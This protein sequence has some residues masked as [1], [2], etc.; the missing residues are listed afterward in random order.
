MSNNRNQLVKCQNQYHGGRESPKPSEMVTERN[1][2]IQRA[3]VPPSIKK[4]ECAH[5]CISVW[6][7][8]KRLTGV[9]RVLD[10]F[11]VALSYITKGKTER[12]LAFCF[13]C[14]FVLHEYGLLVSQSHFKRTPLS[15][16]A[17]SSAMSMCL[18]L[19]CSLSFSLPPISIEQTQTWRQDN[20]L[21]SCIFRNTCAGT[22]LPP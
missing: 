1:V 16:Y 19:T 5:K 17:L 20:V 3:H 21:G 10:Y 12:D 11:W 2:K 18:I 15:K 13:H 9:Y 8:E 22:Q 14:L 4:N 7:L 6:C